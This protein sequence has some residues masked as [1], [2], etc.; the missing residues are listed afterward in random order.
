MNH[1][2]S[3][4]DGVVFSRR[5]MEKDWR[6]RLAGAFLFSD[7]VDYRGLAGLDLQSRFLILWTNPRLWKRSA[8]RMRRMPK[9][10][11]I[12]EVKLLEVEI[13]LSKSR[14]LWKFSNLLG[15]EESPGAL[16]H[17]GKRRRS[18]QRKWSRWAAFRLPCSER[19]ASCWR[20][21]HGCHGRNGET[22]MVQWSNHPK[23]TDDSGPPGAGLRPG[24]DQGSECRD[25][26]LEDLRTKGLKGLNG[27][28]KIFGMGQILQVIKY[29]VNWIELIWSGGVEH[30]FA[31]PA[32]QLRKGN[33]VLSWNMWWSSGPNFQDRNG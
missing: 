33:M 14:Q 8:R 27:C 26:I 10:V 25:G 19:T 31:L 24:T 1:R 18:T 22:N 23:M 7:S 11:Q 20:S 29:H 13:G 5:G 9:H 15:L 6:R 2:G 32:Y 21:R 17:S 4:K 12:D 28:G 30:P 16:R 3:A